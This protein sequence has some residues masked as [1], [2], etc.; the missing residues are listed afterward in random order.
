MEGKWLHKNGSA[1]KWVGGTKAAQI[2]KRGNN[3][4]HELE[5]MSCVCRGFLKPNLFDF[6]AKE[7]PAPAIKRYSVPHSHTERQQEFNVAHCMA[8][9]AELRNLRYDRWARLRKRAS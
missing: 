3:L 9:A 8:C 5:S 7:A 6:S 2:R 4:P 1:K